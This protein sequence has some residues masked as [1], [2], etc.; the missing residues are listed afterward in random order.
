M[1]PARIRRATEDDAPGIAAVHVESWRAAYRGVMPDDVL[2]SLSV[3]RREREWRPRLG[4]DAP[5]VAFVAEHGGRIVGFC[6]VAPSRDDDAGE[7]V[8][9][10]GALYVAQAAWRRGIG[11]LL[12]SAARDELRE[13][14]YRE[15]TLWVLPENAPALAFYERLGFEPDGAEAVRNPGRLRQIRL[16]ARLGS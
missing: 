1:E 5:S 11:S 6:A 9:E 13:A 7:G 2:D 15:L 12:V 4:P 10:V 14:G 8:A 3:D 16:R